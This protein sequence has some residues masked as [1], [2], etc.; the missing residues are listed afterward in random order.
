MMEESQSSCESLGVTCRTTACSQRQEFLNFRLCVGNWDGSLM[1]GK[2]G[3]T[4]ATKLVRFQH[5]PLVQ[6][7]GKGSGAAKA[8]ASHDIGRNNNPAKT[9]CLRLCLPRQM[10]CWVHPGK[11]VRASMF[12]VAS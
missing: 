2:L 6:A 3:R 10:K 1:E 8:M 12:V 11:P 7:I 9:A 4:S 5:G